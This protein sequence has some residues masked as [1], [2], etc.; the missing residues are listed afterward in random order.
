MVCYLFIRGI[1]N[2]TKNWDE[3]CDEE[4]S[5][6]AWFIQ[7]N[8]ELYKEIDSRIIDLLKI[9]YMQGYA[10]GFQAKLDYSSEEYLQK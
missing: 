7:N 10:A 2:M 4:K 6:D 9:A 8:A 5:F 1:E 3:M